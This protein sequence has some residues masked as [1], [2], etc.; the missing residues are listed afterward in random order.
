MF[1]TGC[2]D[3]ITFRTD[4]IIKLAMHRTAKE[5]YSYVT[6]LLYYHLSTHKNPS[7]LR[8]IKDFWLQ[9]VKVPID[10][11][12]IKSYR[13]QLQYKTIIKRKG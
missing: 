10:V 4:N 8:G 7:R 6:A 5:W 11:T 9:I 12:H 1:K 13:Y 3:Q 2:Y